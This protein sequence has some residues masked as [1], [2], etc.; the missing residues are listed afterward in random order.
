MSM[1]LSLLFSGPF[2]ASGVVLWLKA[3]TDDAMMIPDQEVMIRLFSCLQM[4]IGCTKQK[5][6]DSEVHRSISLSNHCQQLHLL[7]YPF[8]KEHR[9]GNAKRVE[10]NKQASGTAQV[11]PY[12]NGAIDTDKNPVGTRAIPLSLNPR[13]IPGHLAPNPTNIPILICRETPTPLYHTIW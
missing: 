7:I 10:L 6:N 9:P 8:G 3:A 1:C 12:V 11:P 2:L 4:Y 13:G 5:A